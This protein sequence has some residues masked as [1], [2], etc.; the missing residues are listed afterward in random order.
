MLNDL[1]GTKAQRVAAYRGFWTALGLFAAVLFGTWAIT[2]ASLIDKPVLA[3]AI[4]AALAA[5]GFRGGVEG[6]ID[7]G[8]T[9]IKPPTK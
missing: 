3:P 4:I 8:N 1:F 9:T 5:L 2:D 7:K 6:A